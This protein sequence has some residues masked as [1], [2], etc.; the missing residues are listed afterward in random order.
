MRARSKVGIG[1]A[2][3]FVGVVVM[4]CGSFG[5][6]DA[7]SPG[8]DAEADAA[9]P[10]DGG[11][12]DGDGPTGEAGPDAGE[13]DASDGCVA[14]PTLTVIAAEADTRVGA[15]A[16]AGSASQGQ[17]AYAYIVSDGFGLFRF[18]LGAQQQAELLAGTTTATL[19]L[20]ADPNCA[21]CGG[22]LPTKAGR[23]VAHS[24]RTD[25]VEGDSTSYSGADA[26]RRTAGNPGTGWGA[27]ADTPS[28]STLIASGI[29]Y[30]AAPGGATLIANDD[31]KVRIRIDRATLGAQFFGK[32]SVAFFVEATNG[33][34]FVAATRE[35]TTIAQ[36][37][38]LEL[39]S[40]P[41]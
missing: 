29:D 37:P 5:S 8:A 22:G 4:A 25:W 15:G 27:G 24:M 30:E 33:G 2:C 32:A 36:R 1:I 16:C 6:D 14:P 26:C 10:A 18:P 13:A 9:T 12:G 7:P 21:G 20:T 3:G 38:R 41:R 34:A 35:T 17:Y 40:C 19:V 31:N 39:V 28:M 11:G 23:I